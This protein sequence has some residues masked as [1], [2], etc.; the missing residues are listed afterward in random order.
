MVPGPISAVA[1]AEHELGHVRRGGRLRR[2]LGRRAAGLAAL[3]QAGRD[4]HPQEPVQPRRDDAVAEVGLVDVHHLGGRI[5]AHAPARNAARSSPARRGVT[6]NTAEC[7]FT[8]AGIPI[9]GTRSPTAAQHVDGGAVAAREQQQVDAGRDQRGRGGAGVV[10]RRALRRRGDR[11]ARQVGSHRAAGGEHLG[12]GRQRRERQ[13]R[14]L[15]RRPVG[16]AGEGG[17]DETAVVR[18]LQRE[19]AADAC[20][21]IHDQ[22]DPQAV[23]LAAL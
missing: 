17:V 19:A 22:A 2:R 20:Q 13:P 9:T 5:A 16:A 8:P 18:A 11:R 4:R 14:P 21:R 23:P 6:P 10:R 1:G 7:I 15:R 3:H 12:A